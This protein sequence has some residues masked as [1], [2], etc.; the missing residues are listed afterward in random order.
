MT[1]R[2]AITAAS[3]QL[4]HNEALRDNATR[5][6][7][8]L[9]LHTLSISRATLLAHPERTLAPTEILSY[10][11]AIHRR[12]NAEP[13][14]YITG[15]QEFF[16]LPFHVSPAVL[17]PRPETELLV[18]SVLER[19][20]P[21]QPLR[22]ADVGTGS[23]IL[24]ITLALHLPL[25]ELTAIDLSPAALAVAH[26]NAETHEVSQRIHLLQS[27][28]LAAA[29]SA[30]FDAIVSNPPYIPDS[31][32]ATLHPQ[33]RDFEPASALFAGPNGLDIYSRLIP[34]ASDA[35]RPGGLLALEI[36][37][38]QASEVRQLLSNWNQIQFLEDLQQ[39]PR[40]AL[41]RKPA[42]SR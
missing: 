22:I 10:H 28:L 2:E 18:E 36:G 38:G 15:T 32:R 26:R 24:A 16:G 31:D 1:I 30:A 17:I 25:A 19:L 20:P 21:D 42:E 23:G 12:G 7:E 11:Q 8:L 33:V 5:D 34:Q 13:I 29:P 41:A 3:T 35:L 14:Q 6:A 9:L 39:I 37:F 27:D 4:A 40:V